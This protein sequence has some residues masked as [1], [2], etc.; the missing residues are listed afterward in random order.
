MKYKINKYTNK[1]V[2]MLIEDSDRLNLLVS[3]GPIGSKVI[4]AG[5]KVDGSIEAGLKI[6]EICLGGLGKVSLVPKQNTPTTSYEISVFA[7]QPVLACL[8]SQ[9]AGWSLSSKDFFSLGSGPVRAIAQKEKIFEEVNYKDSS[10]STCVVLEVD[11]LPPKE[12]VEKISQD[13]NIKS[14]N[15]TFIVTPTT[16]ICGNIQVV[17]RVLEVAIHKIHELKFPLEKI[18]HGYGFAPLPPVANNFLTGMGRTNDAIIYGGIVQLTMKGSDEDLKKLSKKL[19][20]DNSI[21]YGKPFKE[22]F[23]SYGGDFYKIDGSLFSPAAVII[24]SQ[25]SGKSFSSGKINEKLIKTSF[26]S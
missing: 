6:S 22:I 14:E 10:S 3:D 5:I 17:A 16:S 7:S 12:I 13:T 20:S 1:L 9:Y 23:E 2:R 19:P 26:S 18:V 15:I 25:E 8:G 4:D 11:K 21:D 24:N